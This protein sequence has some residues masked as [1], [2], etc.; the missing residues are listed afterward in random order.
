MVVV[1]VSPFVQRILSHGAAL[2]RSPS[3]PSPD[4]KSPEQIGAEEKG[5][6][7]GKKTEEE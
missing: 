4:H 6:G 1:G 7:E 3:S 5:E 2:S